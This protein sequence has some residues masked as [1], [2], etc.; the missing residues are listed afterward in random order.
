MQALLLPV[1]GLQYA[2]HPPD[3]IYMIDMDMDTG[4][5]IYIKL[6]LLPTLGGGLRELGGCALEVGYE[7]PALTLLPFQQ[8]L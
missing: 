3:F 1:H 7:V 2:P 5:D 4:M 8:M 6:C